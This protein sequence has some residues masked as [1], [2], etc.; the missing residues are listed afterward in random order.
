MPPGKKLFAFYVF[1]DLVLFGT[2]GPSGGHIFLDLKKDGA[3]GGR[4]YSREAGKNVK[5][6]S[7][8]TGGRQYSREA[9]KNVNPEA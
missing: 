3:T 1:T 9:G 2:S 7:L 8:A 6:K 4:G 5:P